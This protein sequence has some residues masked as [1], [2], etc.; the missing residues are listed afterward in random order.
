MT[1]YAH[2]AD[3]PDGTPDPDQH[4]WQSLSTH[5]R[6]VADLAKQFAAALPSPPRPGWGEGVGLSAASG[7]HPG[8]KRNPWTCARP[9]TENHGSDWRNAGLS[10]LSWLV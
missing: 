10:S 3:L 9:A 7:V 4:Q 2:T 5:L 8:Y 6:S 1:F